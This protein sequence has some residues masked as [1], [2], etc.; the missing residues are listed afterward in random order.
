[1]WPY[2]DVSQSI[3]FTKVVYFQNVISK[4]R[5]R[6][7]A[8]CSNCLPQRHIAF[9][10]FAWTDFATQLSSYS[11]NNWE[12]IQTGKSGTG[13]PQAIRNINIIRRISFRFILENTFFFHL[14]STNLINILYSQKIPC[15]KNYFE[16]LPLWLFLRIIFFFWLV[17]RNKYEI[18]PAKT[19]KS[20]NIK[21]K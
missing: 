4:A 9:R 18:I 6:C 3:T 13:L 12:R 17:L 19:F 11:H 10:P 14:Y 5:L 8:I 1:M 2:C 20:A 16:I 21:I 15:Y 7:Q